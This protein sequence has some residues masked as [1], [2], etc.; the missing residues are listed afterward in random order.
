MV[1]VERANAEA[2][3]LDKKQRNFDRTLAEWQQ[4]FAESQTEVEA[5][6]RDARSY[7]AD[8]FRLKAQL[9]ESHDQ[10]EGL[11]RE[12]KNLGGKK[13]KILEKIS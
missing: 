12:N 5:A 10:I 8:V 2:S 4:K 3:A 1:D 13:K 6:Q 11:R 9:E 7:S